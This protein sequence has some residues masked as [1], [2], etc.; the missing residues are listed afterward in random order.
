M[1]SKFVVALAAWLLFGAVLIKPK[2]SRTYNSRGLARAR[3]GD[4]AGAIADYDE[5]IRLS[6]TDAD[7]ARVHASRGVAHTA[8]G[9]APAACESLA[10]AIALDP[11]RRDTARTDPV[12]DPIRGD[13]SFQALVAGPGAP[14]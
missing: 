10:A 2:D 12:F 11:H 14:R 1:N 3:K 7:R 6:P 9:D 5:A 13:P 8:M 4:Q